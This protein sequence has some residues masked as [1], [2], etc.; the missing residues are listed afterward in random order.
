MPRHRSSHA[1]ILLACLLAAGCQSAAPSPA[2]APGPGISDSV[3]AFTDPSALRL[4]D[5]RVAMLGYWHAN[6]RLPARIED[7]QRYGEVGTHLQFVSPGSGQAYVYVPTGPALPGKS[8]RLVLYDPTPFQPGRFWGI[9]ISPTGADQPLIT[10][11]KPLDAATLAA[12]QRSP[13]PPAAPPAAPS[14]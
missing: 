1:L 12:Y 7:L 6:G 10:W 13:A 3:L 9:L 8:E 2:P 4:D 11:I 14:Q 5:I